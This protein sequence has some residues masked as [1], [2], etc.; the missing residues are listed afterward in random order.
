M[1]PGHPSLIV[2][3]PAMP[4]LSSNTHQRRYSEFLW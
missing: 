1:T 3:Q 4:A 2:I